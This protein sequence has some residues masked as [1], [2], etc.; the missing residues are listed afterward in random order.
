M[1]FESLYALFQEHQYCGELDGGVEGDRVWMTR[2]C[3]AA[4][5]R[6]DDD[7]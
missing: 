7:D 6:P 4:I 2:T 1:L 5:N 3:G